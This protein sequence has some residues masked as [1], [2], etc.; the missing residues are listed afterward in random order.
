MFLYQLKVEPASP[1]TDILKESPIQPFG[2]FTKLGLA[3]LKLITLTVVSRQK[4]DL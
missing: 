1:V 4:S 2:V 3:G